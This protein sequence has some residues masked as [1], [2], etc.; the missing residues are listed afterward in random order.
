MALLGAE[1]D[2]IDIENEYLCGIRLEKS[3]SYLGTDNR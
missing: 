2:D 3:R 1:K